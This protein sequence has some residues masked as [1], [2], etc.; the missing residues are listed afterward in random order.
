M[1]QISNNKS[2]PF[3]ILK[4]AETVIGRAKSVTI[5]HTKIN[6][7]SQ[8][9]DDKFIKG[10]DE[11]EYGLGLTGNYENDIQL[12]LVEDAVNF[13]FWAEKNKDKW[14]VEWPKGNIV[15]GGWCGLIASFERALAE[16]VP[17]LDPSFLSTL[18]LKKVK[19]IFRS[20]SASEMPLINKRLENLIET[21]EVLIKKY[22]GKAVNL[23]E[24]ANL[25]AIKIV[26]LVC[27]NFPSFRDFAKYD[28]NDVYFLKR[29]QIFANDLSY[30]SRIGKKLEIKNLDKLTAFA[31]YKIPQILRHFGVINYTKEL[32]EKVDHYKLI[33]ASSPEE[34]EIRAATIQGVDLIKNNLKKY[35]SSQVDNAI[36]LISQDQSR[37]DRPYHRTY[38]IYY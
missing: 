33:K 17:I 5:D 28:G 30:V 3:N 15:S 29:A 35:T 2:D 21:G 36:W 23:L 10:F 4:T 25:D 22:D 12:L 31:D 11:N 24:E 37:I 14:K 19:E 16:K 6:K 13:C 32:A 1:I 7:I 27:N 34:V 8:L 38:S 18:S 26:E 20:A 9:V